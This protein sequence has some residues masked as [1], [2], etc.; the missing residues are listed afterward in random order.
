M[1]CVCFITVERSG[2][3]LADVRRV[4][5]RLSRRSCTSAVDF[6]LSPGTDA[7]V[8]ERCP[9]R[10]G[11]HLLFLPSLQIISNP[12]KLLHL[13]FQ[14]RRSSRQPRN[15]VVIEYGVSESQTGMSE[16]WKMLM[17]AMQE[18]ATAVKVTFGALG[19]FRVDWIAEALLD[20]AEHLEKRFDLPREVSHTRF[21]L[22]PP[23]SA[24]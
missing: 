16:D 9:P 12:P 24:A 15:L 2:Y 20:E 7:A 10:L 18:G 3:P 4:L 6:V 11:R 22:R 21:P 14:A 19:L 1:D 17:S 8:D 23:Q 13:F 5:E